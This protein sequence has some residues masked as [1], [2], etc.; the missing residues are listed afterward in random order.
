[1][2]MMTDGNG[3][4]VES[5]DVMLQLGKDAAG[6]FRIRISKGR[7]RAATE[8]ETVIILDRLPYARKL[9]R[10]ARSMRAT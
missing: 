2:V 1:M 3:C 6:E 5:N 10:R 8:N 4:E 9:H 7:Y